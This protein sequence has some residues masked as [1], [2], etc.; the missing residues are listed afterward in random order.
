MGVFIESHNS[1]T[2]KKAILEDND[3]SCWLYLID[4]N[5]QIERDTF[6]YSPIEPNETLDKEK[7]QNGMPPELITS[8]ASSEAILKNSQ[9]EDFELKWSNDGNSIF[10]L[11]NKV[12]ITMLLTTHKY[13]FSKALKVKSGFGHPW[14][15]ELFK[16]YFSCI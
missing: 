1:V 2:N 12:P 3:R 16:D 13:G 14:D 11:H 9:E 6:V 15:K 4:S 5:G 7:I 8:L 10:V